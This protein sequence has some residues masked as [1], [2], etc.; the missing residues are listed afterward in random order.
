MHSQIPYWMAA[1]VTTTLGAGASVVRAAPVPVPALH[2]PAY[3]SPAVA[4]RPAGNN[5]NTPAATPVLPG[6]TY[7]TP[8]FSA[9]QQ[10]GTGGV[11]GT[12]SFTEGYATVSPFG[13]TAM[14]QPGEPPFLEGLS[15]NQGVGSSINQPGV[16]DFYDGFGFNRG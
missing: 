15:G 10:V 6:Q 2:P 1:V 12:P 14:T 5:F 7:I 16:P 11:P 4:A 9:G 8:G 13:S 3:V